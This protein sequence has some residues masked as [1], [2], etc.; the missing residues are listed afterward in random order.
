MKKIYFLGLA[1]AA[2]LMLASC[3]QNEPENTVEAAGFEEIVLGDDNTNAHYTAEGVT[4]FT[5]GNFNFETYTN[6]SDWGTYYY[7]FVASAQQDN[8]FESYLDAY[9][10]ACG[11]AKKGNAFAVWYSSYYGGDAI[12]LKTAAVVPGC[13][14]TN[15]AYAANSMK[16]GD[17]Y[18]KKF[19]ADDWFK[20]TISG[21]KGETATGTVDFYLAKDGK[22][23][24]TWEYCDLSSLGEVDKL[25]FALSSTDNGDYGMNTPAYFCIDELGAKK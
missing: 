18:A 1:L 5:S 9:K 14:L 2:G 21:Y 22:I 23:V 15:N 7:G 12:T 6:V 25:T 19:G 11:G 20:L 17:A 13:Y 8:N 10:S 24:E 16:N 4:T 3:Q